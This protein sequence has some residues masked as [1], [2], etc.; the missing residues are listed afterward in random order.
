MSAV[1]TTNERE[2]D[3]MSL[4]LQQ[5]SAL[6]TQFENELNEIGRQLE[7]LH[8]ARNR[9]LSSKVAVEQVQGYDDNSQ[10]MIPLANSLYVPGTIVDSNKYLM[11]L[12][13]GYFCEKSG[14]ASIALIE[15]KTQLVVDSMK[16]IEE[17]G[18]SKRQQLSGVEQVMRLKLHQSQQ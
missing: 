1:T 7:A 10:V 12:G 17:V 3:I 18:M 13:T 15:R 9:F 16:K 14:E 2:I 5:L 6:K 11:E 8:G 4:D